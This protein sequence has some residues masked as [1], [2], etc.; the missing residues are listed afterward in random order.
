M[1]EY[2]I[3]DPQGARR[4]HML[5]WRVLAL[6]SL[7][8]ALLAAQVFAY[9]TGFVTDALLPWAWLAVVD[10]VLIGMIALLVRFAPRVPLF[11]WPWPL[12]LFGVDPPA[13]VARLFRSRDDLARFSRLEW[14]V[15]MWTPLF[16]LGPLYEPVH[17]LLFGRHGGID[18]AHVA[19]VVGFDVA[20]TVLVIAS[21]RGARRWRDLGWRKVA[22][23]REDH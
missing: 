10:V 13:K 14:T 21:I 19:G 22:D 5:R 17:D 23:R 9:A 3:N 18:V 8:G 11:W 12:L 16:L 1:K 6:T 4:R 15:G 20:V 7:V 2:D